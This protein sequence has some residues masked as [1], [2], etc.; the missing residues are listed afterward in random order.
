MYKETLEKNN[1]EAIVRFLQNGGIDSD[2]KFKCSARRDTTKTDYRNKDENV[3]NN[4]Y[5]E[6][7]YII[8]NLYSEG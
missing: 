2:G 1:Q 6:Q 3:G 5:V 8:T 7:E 4:Q